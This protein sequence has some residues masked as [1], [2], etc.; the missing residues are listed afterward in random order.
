[1]SAVVRFDEPALMRWQEFDAA[2]TAALQE[3]I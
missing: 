2:V 1:V 3:M